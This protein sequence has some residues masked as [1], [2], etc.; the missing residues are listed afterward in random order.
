[1]SDISRRQGETPL[2]VAPLTL[3]EARAR[4]EHGIAAYQQVREVLP[5][6]DLWP[7]LEA[8]LRLV[9]RSLPPGGTGYPQSESDPDRLM[10]DYRDEQELHFEV[11]A[12]SMAHDFMG[13]T[14]YTA[15]ADDRDAHS[16]AHLL[17]LLALEVLEED[18]AWEPHDVEWLLT[19]AVPVALSGEP[20]EYALVPGLLRGLIRFCHNEGGV[21]TAE[22]SRALASVTRHEPEYLRLRDDPDIVAEREAVAM[23][24]A[25]EYAAAGLAAYLTRALGSPEAIAALDDRPLPD[26]ALDVAGLPADVT[27]RVC[28]VTALS[29][30]VAD[31]LFDVEIRTAT[32]RLLVLVAAG[33]PA[34]FRRRSDDAR[35]AAAALWIVTMANGRVGWDAPVQVKQLLS[36][37]GLAGSIS[38]RAEPMLAAI[39]ATGLLRPS[40]LLVGTPVL[41]T[42]T[43]RADLLQLRE[44]AL[45][46]G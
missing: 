44:R 4:I 23:A 7:G 37:F 1:M 42:S 34:I 19:E 24:N 25:A 33:D 31:E 8:L 12:D 40:V 22:T 13:S 2:E 38:Q 41:L 3:P 15:D 20:R 29:D 11:E 39:G 18:L 43:M 9:A 45:L 30:R 28:R 27:E 17:A 6:Q 14:F 21:P 46:R 26:E 5:N 35:L 16:V 32:R 10:D 36:A